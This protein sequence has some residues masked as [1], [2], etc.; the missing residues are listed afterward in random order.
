MLA[1]YTPVFVIPRGSGLSRFI[2]EMNIATGRLRPFHQETG[3]FRCPF[4]PNSTDE[5][6]DCNVA[7]AGTGIERESEAI[8]NIYM[9]PSVTAQCSGY[10]VICRIHIKIRPVTAH[11]LC[12]KN[13][14]DT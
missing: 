9:V 1:E 6:R 14:S 10:H 3:N 4:A 13:P 2:L 11:I 12:I 7:A 8:S 5:I